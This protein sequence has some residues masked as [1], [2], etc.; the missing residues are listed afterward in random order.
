M[1]QNGAKFAF[2]GQCCKLLTC[3]CKGV[4][5]LPFAGKQSDL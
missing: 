3:R 2:G 5:A 1:S 4:D